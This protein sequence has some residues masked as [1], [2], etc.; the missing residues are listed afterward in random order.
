MDVISQGREP[1]RDPRRSLSLSKR[2]RIGIGV[3]LVVVV[4]VLGV[5][6]LRLRHAAGTPGAT[7]A[8]E[9]IPTSRVLNEAPAPVGNQAFFVC[10]PSTGQ[11]SVRIGVTG[12]NASWIVRTRPPAG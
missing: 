9:T 10:D 11:C 6:G 12:G 5:A 2:W 8:P 4:A 1:R 3:A 7:V